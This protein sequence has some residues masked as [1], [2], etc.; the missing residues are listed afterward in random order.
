MLKSHPF[1]VYT[2]QRAP[3][4]MFSRPKLTS[5][6]LLSHAFHVTAQIVSRHSVTLRISMKLLDIKTF[7]CPVP[8][9]RIRTDIFL[10]TPLSNTLNLRTANGKIA[11]V[12][13]LIVSS[14]SKRG[15]QV[16]GTAPPILKN[17]ARMGWV[18]SGTL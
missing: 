12:D 4:F 13:N 17:G 10:S 15:C 6:S 1:S 11:A 9:I 16:G 3:S 2:L 5:I 7:E 8:S 14:I 18:V